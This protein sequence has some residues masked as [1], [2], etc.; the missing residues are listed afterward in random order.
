MTIGENAFAPSGLPAQAGIDGGESEG[1]IK[2]GS[3][4]M[5]TRDDA[6]AP[7]GLP[8]QA[9]IDGGESEGAIARGAFAL[10]FAAAPRVAAR[11]LEDARL[12][13]VLLRRGLAP[14]R[15]AAFVART[16]VAV[17]RIVDAD[18][19]VTFQIVM[20]SERVRSVAARRRASSHTFRVIPK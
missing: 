1:A 10:T 2:K 14:A 20:G 17:R 13:A 7:S 19:R 12:R 9:G 4:G 18:M 15:A 3:P 5:T 6:F 11:R 8:A 16:G